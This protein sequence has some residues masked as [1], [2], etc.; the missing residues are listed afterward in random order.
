MKDPDALTKELGRTWHLLETSMKPYPACKC[1][2]TEIEALLS[3]IQE[4]K[5]YAQDIASIHVKESNFNYSIVVYQ[6]TK[7]TSPA[8]SR[9]PNLVYPMFYPLLH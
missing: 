3:L 5:F 7:F 4:H 1:T 9:N 8:L 6:K 2:H